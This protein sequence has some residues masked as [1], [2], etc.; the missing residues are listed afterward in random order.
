M[1]QGM[2]NSEN[3][4]EMLRLYA[5]TD[6]AWLRGMTLSQQVEQAI[7]GGATMVQLREKD[8]H[9][10]ALLAEAREIAEVCHKHGVP[11][12]IDDDVQVAKMCGADG[13]HVGQ[14]DM[15]CEEARRILGEDAIIGVTAK[16]IEQAQ[17]AQAAGAD[18]LGSGAVFGT[19]T[20]LNAK[21][22]TRETLA[23]ITASVDIPVV[24]IGGINMGNIEKLEGTGIAGVAVVSGIF[25]A[26]DIE[27]ECRELRKIA[28]RIS[29]K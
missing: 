4:S 18:Y 5:V 17:R 19:S 14:D 2:K 11:L 6:R 1:E 16:T 22:M 9:G 29:V 10:E 26:E 27:S 25:A 7:L 20:K 8:M 21:P 3:I 24:A 12:L 28:D 15:R 13:V 23:S